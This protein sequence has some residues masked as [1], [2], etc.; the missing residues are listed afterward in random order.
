MKI[1]IRPPQCNKTE[2]MIC[3]AAQHYSYIVVPSAAAV[4]RLWGRIAELDL[5]TSM[6]HP[7][8]WD[9]FLRGDYH[10]GYSFV[11]DDLDLCLLSM[12]VVEIKAV[13]LTG[14]AA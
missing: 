3:L 4:D 12:T 8:T 13:A 10:P 14:N 11:I 7:I 6:P 1:I 2:D 5:T 9:Q